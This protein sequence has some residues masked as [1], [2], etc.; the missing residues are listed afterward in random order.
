MARELADAGRAVILSRQGSTKRHAAM[1]LGL[2]KI[3][4]ATHP[5]PD[6]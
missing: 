5:T 6:H 1:L 4:D 3:N 2:L